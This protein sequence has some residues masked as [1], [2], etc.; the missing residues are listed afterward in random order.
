MF[1]K[2]YFC[3]GKLIFASINFLPL[4]TFIVIHNLWAYTFRL[5]IKFP[6]PY[7]LFCD[8]SVL[9]QFDHAATHSTASLTNH[10]VIHLPSPL[11]TCCFIW[12]LSKYF[13]FLS[14]VVV[15]FRNPIWTPFL[16]EDFC[17]CIILSSKVMHRTH[18]WPSSRQPFLF[19]QKQISWS[20]SVADLMC[21]YLKSFESVHNVLATTFR[22]SLVSRC[23]GLSRENP[24]S[25]T[26][27]RRSIHTVYLGRVL[28]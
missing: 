16:I 8:F 11:F 21:S 4:I 19:T 6:L 20:F 9:S 17:L 7:P 1:L 24:L 12:H 25:S 28:R 23:S 14:T 2:I 27:S 15:W 10:L 3:F 18:F 22:S 26:S 5:A 13:F